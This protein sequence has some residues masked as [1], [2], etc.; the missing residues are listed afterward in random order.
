MTMP[1][2]DSPRPHDGGSGNGVPASRARRAL[3]TVAAVGI[4]LLGAVAVQAPASAAPNPAIVVSDVVLSTEDGGPAT[5][6]DVIA[7]SG[8][9]DAVDADPVP[10]DTFTIA[11]PPELEFPAAITFPLNGVNG[12]GEPVVFGTCVTDP[13]TGIATCT[14]SDAVVG[15]VDIGGSFEFDLRA[16]QATT[17]EEVVF[18]L[19]GILTPVDLPG[20]G[21]IDDGIDPPAEWNKTGAMNANHWS[22][23]WT[24]DLPGDRLAGHDVVNVAD[25]LGSGH[26]LCDPSNLRVRSVL[27][28]GTPVDVPGILSLTPGAD[29][30]HFTI[31]LSEPAGGWN[32]NLTYRITYDTCTIDGGIDPQ[33]TEY[34]NEA[35][36]DIWGESSGVIGVTQDWSISQTLTK[37]GSVLGGAD[38]NGRIVWT[39]IVPG[40]E[41]V[42]KDGFTLEES[43][44]GEHE[45]RPETINGIRVFE[46]YGPSDDAR[47]EVSSRLAVTEVSSSATEFEVDIDIVDPSFAFKDSDF[48]YVIQYSTYATTDGLPE[49]GTAFTNTATID[50]DTTSTTA[51][52]PGRTDNKRGTINGS[53]V[54]IDGVQHLPQTT[55]GWTITVPGERLEGIGGDLTIT[56]TLSASQQVCAACDVGTGGARLGLV[57][58]AIDQIA[59]GG[60]ASVVLPATAVADGQDIVITIPRPESLPQPG[61]GTVDGFSHEYQYV[62]QYTTCT[63]S[64][65]MD[66]PGTAYGNDAQVAGQVYGWTATQENRSSGTGQGVTSGSVA[67]QKVLADTPGAD[68]VPT[69]T[70]FTVHAREISPTG[71]VVVEYDLDVPLDGTPV[72]GFNPR[73]TG[74]TIELS[75]PAFP[76]VP[77]VEFGDPVFAASPGVTPSADGTTAVV[78]LTPAT[79]IGVTLTNE[80]LLAAITI[81]KEVV[82]GADDD[83]LE[84][85]DPELDFEVVA[86]ISG[87][88]GAPAQPD[89]V[90]TIRD[91]EVIGLADLPIGAT[92]TF[93]ETVPATDDVLTWSPAI[94]SPETIVVPSATAEPIAVQVT[95]T[96]QRTLGTV[97]VA[98]TVTGDEVD[99]PAVP[100][101][102][103]VT[104][105]WQEQG[106]EPASTEL[107]VSTDSA[108]PCTPL[109]EDLF[110]GTVVTFE[111]TVLDDGDGIAWGLPIW[112]GDGIDGE[113]VGDAV[114][115]TI[116]R[117]AEATIALENPTVSLIDLA[118]LK[119]FDGAAAA[120]VPTGT[121]FPVAASW[122]NARGEAQEREIEIR[123]GET[124]LIEGIPAGTEVELVEGSATLPVSVQ[125]SGVAW[126]T[127][128]A[129]ALSADG[130][131]LTVLV[132]DADVE[133][134]DIVTI[135]A[136]NSF[137]KLALTGADLDWL[138]IGATA[139]LI[140][141]LGGAGLL[142]VRRVRAA[143]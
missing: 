36:V 31:S 116:G 13:A 133:G 84:R 12:S 135:T 115:V 124:T 65:G 136:T 105:T 129:A 125:W 42:G 80:A 48:M 27:G 107:T 9:W 98:K 88:V 2:A 70:V 121:A 5:I 38:R 89:R 119:A 39:V 101:S 143:S 71:T 137:A 64:G 60:L 138:P 30:Q 37:S 52:T 100:D 117:D 104:A 28:T 68:L 79:N 75:E 111:E 130:S 19:N 1:E 91:G 73:G 134:G 120:D 83:A 17:A 33:G 139:A 29:D 87:P 126:A 142:T 59:G 103:T 77:G 85:V 99:N 96:V 67:V 95:N 23:G 110:I 118:I 112:S 122:T 3:A 53:T 106:R 102:V 57:V 11:L 50:G 49:G 72:S 15:L 109:G 82:A 61:G 74:W 86:Q 44:G 41:L 56:D 90:I 6:G 93:S 66:A 141:L 132:D 63:T 4:A 94:I 123:V 55:L 76:S 81:T 92:V 7:V 10:G 40:H 54:T 47:V 18:D 34:T 14:I 97:C 131:R 113:V 46:R 20:T 32:P 45:V 127:E 140:L 58:R 114:E 8:T 43:L 69:G 51:T 21:G 26:R 35:T 25:A 22:M 62:V 24:I 108:E 128:D 78:A 16:A